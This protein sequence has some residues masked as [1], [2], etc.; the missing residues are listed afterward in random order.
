[1]T[2]GG[3]ARPGN[4][5]WPQALV[6][7]FSDLPPAYRLWVAFSGGLDS[8]LLLH[9]AHDL[10][11]GRN[12]GPSV[13][14][15]HINH[16]LQTN[17][18][19]TE[20][21]CR[22][23]C[24]QLDV[25]LVI[26]PVDLALA[27]SR[28]GLEAAARNARYRVFETLLQRRDVLLMAHHSD[29]QAETVLFRLIRGS[30]LAGLGGMPKTRVLGLGQL[31]RPLLEFG[32][33]ELECWA[34]Q[35]GIDWVDDPSNSDRTFDRNFLRHEVMP[36]LKARWPNLLVRF[37]A[38]ARYCREQ[39]SLADRLAEIQLEQCAH[40]R[41]GLDLS[42]FSRLSMAER[43]NLLRW[44]VGSQGF[45]VPSMRHWNNAVMQ[46]IEARPDGAPRIQ[47]AGYSIDRF[48]SRL[49]LV[50]DPSQL[51]DS[52]RTLTPSQPV[53]WGELTV[54]LE[55]EPDPGPPPRLQVD[56]RQG[57]ERIRERPG[58]RS[59]PLK[60][61]LQEKGVAP[62]QRACLGLVWEGG[63]LV[64][65]GNLWVSERYAG[66][67]PASGWRIVWERDFN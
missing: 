7:A 37:A 58:G 17:A 24:D 27:E 12:E 52:G 64:A 25:P 50:P 11:S 9:L 22:E 21:H 10:F 42:R 33:A 30:G 1:M 43:K 62:W 2:Q 13:H 55:P 29:D 15:I 34:V 53:P 49:V 28:A 63:E 4:E 45:P 5:R 14:A 16:Q 6:S 66:P 47:G 23:I 31:H 40:P 46:L 18:A 32:R 61:W 65:V 59:R 39:A 44:W 56:Q 51:P 41:G 48:Q 3:N 8:T 26:E 60:K 36:V 19:A 54:R 57:G 67:A 38:S 35:A 20:R